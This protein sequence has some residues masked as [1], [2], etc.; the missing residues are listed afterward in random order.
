MKNRDMQ[1]LRLSFLVFN[2]F[3]Q[4]IVYTFSADAPNNTIYPPE[5]LAPLWDHRQM[6][7]SVSPVT[8]KPRIHARSSPSLRPL[9]ASPDAYADQTYTS[10]TMSKVYQ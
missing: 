2:T 10:P 8:G 4:Y 3:S 6:F 1:K 7:R 5:L 9:V